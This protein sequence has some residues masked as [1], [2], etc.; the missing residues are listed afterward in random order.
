MDENVITSWIDGMAFESELGGHKI[1]VDASEE[2]GGMNRGP[3]PKAMLL[4]ALGGCTGM[5]VIAI[6]DKMKLKPESFRV[7]VSADTQKEHP[8]VYDMIHVKY[9]FKGK[10]LPHEKLEKAVNLSRDKY[11]AVNAMLGKS[12]VISAEIIVED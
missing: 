9:I 4:S 8:K 3:R 5:D 11:C 6:L 10:D 2:F 1:I 7:E 12:A